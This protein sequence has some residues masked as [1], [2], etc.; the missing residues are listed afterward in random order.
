[1]MVLDIR[2]CARS[3]DE[4]AEGKAAERHTLRAALKA[5]RVPA[6]EQPTCVGSEYMNPPNIR[7]ALDAWLS[8][9]R[10]RR[11]APLAYKV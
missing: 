4:Y 10:A 3:Y 1:M 11:D 7:V 9:Q 2:G 5:H 6:R 8:Y